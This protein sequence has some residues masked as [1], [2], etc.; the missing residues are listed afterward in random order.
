M[1]CSIGGKFVDT[2]TTA[3]E[4]S[5][6]LAYT[7]GKNKVTPINW[8]CLQVLNEDG[9]AWEKIANNEKTSFSFDRTINTIPECGIRK[10][11]AFYEGAVQPISIGTQIY[12]RNPNQWQT[13]MHTGGI[14]NDI[15]VGGTTTPREKGLQPIPNIRIAS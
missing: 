10:D 3:V 15:T 6:S 1:K 12:S 4:L 9:D 14:R 7:T 8:G 13:R 5:D 2:I 11:T